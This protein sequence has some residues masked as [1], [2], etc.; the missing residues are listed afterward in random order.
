MTRTATYGL[1]NFQRLPFG[2]IYYFFPVWV[3]HH[4][5]TLV[6]SAYRDRLIEVAELPP[7]SLLLAGALPILL[8]FLLWRRIR[9]QQ[10]SPA[11]S[12]AVALAG[13]LAI[14]AVL[15]LI[16]IGMTYRYRME[17][18]PLSELLA[19]VA[20][21]GLAHAN[22]AVPLTARMR[23]A[24]TL[25]TAFEVVVSHFML[26]LYKLS[27]FGPAQEHLQSGILALY[28]AQAARKIH[29]Y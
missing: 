4:D 18:F 19:F 7:G 3:L 17:F 20:I 2:L 11:S 12:E 29:L 27:P 10:W 24:I 16:A 6:L 13:G 9:R 22:A 23:G 14:P 15:M 21:F 1:F 26:V 25:V 5:N 28:L 8:C